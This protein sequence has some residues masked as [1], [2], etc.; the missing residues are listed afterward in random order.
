M[1]KNS[2]PKSFLRRI[3]EKPN[4]FVYPIIIIS[5]FSIGILVIAC[6]AKLF[7]TIMMAIDLDSI[8]HLDTG[9]VSSEL[10]GIIDMVLLIILIYTTT[11]ALYRFFIGEEI[12]CLA[13]D[14]KEKFHSSGGKQTF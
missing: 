12:P 13:W 3:L 6:F 4:W 1:N 8:S 2:L 9:I 11:L 7:N 14:I 5:F 10:L